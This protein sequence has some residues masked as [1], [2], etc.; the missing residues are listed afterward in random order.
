MNFL[1]FFKSGIPQSLLIGTLLVYIIPAQYT[2]FI[3]YNQAQFGTV[4]E[5]VFFLNF[6]TQ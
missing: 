3:W 2:F 4:R 6:V 1:F 5:I